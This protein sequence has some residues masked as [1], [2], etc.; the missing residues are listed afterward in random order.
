MYGIFGIFDDCV[1]G[2][3]TFALRL[4]LVFVCLCAL[5][6]RFVSAQSVATQAGSTAISASPQVMPIVPPTFPDQG[7]ESLTDI[8]YVLDENGNYIP[9]MRGWTVSQVEAIQK[10]IYNR[11]PEPSYSIQ[12]LSVEGQVVDNVANLTV[13]LR[14]QTQ[15]EPFVRV[16]IGLKSGIFAVSSSEDESDWS[17]AVQYDGPGTFNIMADPKGNGYEMILRAKPASREIPD[18]PI[19]ST[20]EPLPENGG[21]TSTDDVPANDVPDAEAASS[22]EAVPDA[23]PAEPT[24]TASESETHRVIH[25]VTLRMAFPVTQPSANEYLLKAEFPPALNSHLQLV[26]PMADAIVLQSKGGSLHQTVPFDERSTLLV[27][28]G[29]QG[30]FEVQWH[31]KQRTLVRERVVL[32]VENGNIV[33]RL[34]PT[35]AVFDATIPVQS[36]GGMFDSLKLQ[37]PPGAVFRPAQ[38]VDTTE[39]QIE[40]LP[41]EQGETSDE[42]GQIALQSQV[43][44]IRM[45]RPTEG[46]VQ[47]RLQAETP[48]NHSQNGW[49]ELGGFDVLGAEKQFG[50]LSVV[51]P[52]ETRLRPPKDS[53]GIRPSSH[54]TVTETEGV[55]TSFEYYE[56]P[57][58]LLTQAVPQATRVH[59][60]PEYQ[61]EIIN[62]NHAVL[63]AKLSYTIHGGQ[64]Q[65]VVDMN[66]WRLTDIG[67]DNLVNRDESSFPEDGLVTVPLLEPVGRK[68]DLNLRAER[69]FDSADGEI[70][71]SFPVPEADVVEPALVAVIPADNIELK[72]DEDR[73]ITEMTLKSRRNTPLEIELP[74]R[75][76]GAMI[77]QIDHPKR[78]EFCARSILQPQKISVQSQTELSLLTDSQVVQTLF[79]TVDY[80]R[81]SRL[82]LAVPI[83]LNDQDNLKVTYESR[84][85][86]LFDLPE[87]VER[88][89]VPEGVTLKQVLLPDARIGS[90]QL[91][92]NFNLKNQNN[93]DLGSMQPTTTTQVTV[94]IVLPY[95]GRLLQETVHVRYPREIRLNHD[96]ETTGWVKLESPSLTAGNSPRLTNT[97][98]T[99]KATS[100]LLLGASLKNA[101][102][103]GT[104]SVDKGWVRCWLL[105]SG[106]IDCACY[107]VTTRL[108][109]FAI[110]L[111]EHIRGEKV[112]IYVDNRRINDFERKGRDLRIPLTGLP[113][114][115]SPTTTRP[116]TVLLDVPE[117]GRTRTIEIQYEVS[118]HTSLNHFSLEMPKFSSDTI[119][120]P[121][122]CQVV[123]PS[124]RHLIACRQDWMPQFQWRFADGRF[125][126]KSELAQRELED[127]VGVAPGEPVS[128]D[129]NSYLFISFHPETNVEIDVAD[130]STLVLV[131]SG[132]VLL[133]G[134]MVI[135][136][137]RVRY[138]G[139]IL[140][141][142]VLFVSFF[143][144]RVTLTII[145][146]QAGAVGFLLVLIASFLYR[147]FVSG[148]SWKTLPAR[149]IAGHE[150]AG[151][152]LPVDDRSGQRSDLA[153]VRVAHGESEPVD[154]RSSDEGTQIFPHP[155]GNRQPAT[156]K[157]QEDASAPDDEREI[158]RPASEAPN[159]PNENGGPHA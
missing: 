134:L 141:S 103:L 140:T 71:F 75:R 57:C 139:V 84:P 130:R 25:T 10:M 24:G 22:I 29:V 69:T 113:G 40:E 106:R 60:R 19:P 91:T 83:E 92:V 74:D 135:Y 88:G 85:L 51:V 42:S 78:A 115:S 28:R 147:L 126:R 37:L 39:Y 23:P 13:Q 154:S 138:P 4:A 53:R 119:V 62:R 94:P 64:N 8:L 80:E 136:F 50:N 133:F 56:Q 79:Y 158:P 155:T 43:L 73:P 109:H 52:R 36:S 144:Y 148:D 145:F 44:L 123:L 76:Q 6:S 117:S 49:F 152:L 46:P 159:P 54:A 89:S 20:T 96:E 129:L 67:P 93:V 9:V 45:A 142:L 100:T 112:F 98:R 97:Y 116:S 107:R 131:S 120:R 31:E 34:T 104:A 1:D 18:A 27:F 12:S 11:N 63:R 59:L 114:D 149:S 81:V 110:T 125:S 3:K 72:V 61:V 82:T 2:G 143:V 132:L 47:V 150:T 66:G 48:I 33:A 151:P 26:V 128:P 102:L 122:Y 146:L 99:E 16:P 5:S 14:I 118:M 35:S 121:V 87:P 90:F 157:D 101:D 21:D 15:N 55:V 58:S 124:S 41:P 68:I 38:P 153:R 32:Q 111:P 156:T 137:P 95:D 86:T 108:S 65:L 70:R 30:D 7:R 77:Y 17:R 127:W 105:G